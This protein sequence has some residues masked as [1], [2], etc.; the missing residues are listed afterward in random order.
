VFNKQVTPL[1]EIVSTVEGLELVDEALPKPANKFLPEWWRTTPLIETVV[2]TEEAIIGNVKN[3]PS[4]PDYFSKGII[5]PMWTDTLLKYDK[6]TNQFSWRTS[7]PAFTWDVHDHSQFLSHVPFK[8]FNQNGKFVFKANCPWNII[9]PPGYSVYQLPLFYHY[10]NEFMVFP[11]VVDTDTHHVVNQQLL[12]TAE[13]DEIFIKR[14]TPLVQYVPFKR[15]DLNTEVRYQTEEDK[16]N[17]SN[18]NLSFFTKFAGSKQYI[19]KRKKVERD[20]R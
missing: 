1:I 12:L 11:G 5:I 2:T 7:H 16:K 3:C 10:T 17:F 20:G 8:F 4:F 13:K 6:N 18:F 19:S 15:E 14:G 9:T